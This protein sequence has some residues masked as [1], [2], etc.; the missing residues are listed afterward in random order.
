MADRIAVMRAGGFEQ[1]APKLEVYTSP[2]TAFVAS[3]V[4]HANRLRGRLAA[5]DGTTARLDWG[6][7]ALIVP[8]PSGANAGDGVDYFVKCEHLSI[9]PAA[10][11]AGA[12]NRLD[13]TLRDIIFKGQVADYMVT[14]SDGTEIVVSE[15]ATV[16]R[17]KPQEAVAV[18]WPIEAGHCFRAGA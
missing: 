5:V 18:T 11:P 6:G 15:P 7:A 14:L 4:G 10:A 12:G 8:R 9:A 2:A 17:L 1:V 13:G 3:F 16:P